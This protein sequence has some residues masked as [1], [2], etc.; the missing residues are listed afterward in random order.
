MSHEEDQ[1]KMQNS[2]IKEAIKNTNIYSEL[3]LF[4]KGAIIHTYEGDLYDRK[5]RII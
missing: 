5:Y 1:R 4:V 3:T 2:L